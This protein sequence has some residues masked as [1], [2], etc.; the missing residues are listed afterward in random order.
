MIDPREIFESVD[1]ILGAAGES[2]S[3][4][5]K[6]RKPHELSLS[7]MEL[8]ATG[9]VQVT[10]TSSRQTNAAMPPIV[11]N[12]AGVFEIEQ[13][14]S[15][16]FER[17]A[18]ARTDALF[19]PQSLAKA[20]AAELERELT[21]ITRYCLELDADSNSLLARD[22]S[23]NVGLPGTYS[24]CAEPLLTEFRVQSG[25]RGDVKSL[26]DARQVTFIE[27][28]RAH[29]FGSATTAE[30]SMALSRA[31]SQGTQFHRGSSTNYP[32]MPGG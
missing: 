14:A 6:K 11:S 28:R 23:S 7:L 3:D 25:Q 21:D 5:A 8:G 1:G 26:V 31:P 17:F 20:S 27:A 19:P 22:W 2:S 15:C 10:D 4:E 30:N 16:S 29:A 12:L 32:F 13:S 9:F 18:R 24:F